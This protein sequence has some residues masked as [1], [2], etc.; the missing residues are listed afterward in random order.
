MN[1]ANSRE[2]LNVNKRENGETTFTYERVKEPFIPLIWLHPPHLIWLWVIQGSFALTRIYTNP[3]ILRVDVFGLMEAL[4]TLDSCQCQKRPI[5]DHWDG[6]GLQTWQYIIETPGLINIEI[7]LS[8]KSWISKG[9]SKNCF[10]SH[11]F[12][13]LLLE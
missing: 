12:Y 8:Y 3:Q 5:K 9:Q 2:F 1:I 13:V 11:D 6:N 10:L 7:A 4:R